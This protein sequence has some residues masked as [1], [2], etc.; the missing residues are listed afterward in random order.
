MTAFSTV[1]TAFDKGGDFETKNRKRN[2]ENEANRTSNKPFNGV[3]FFFFFGIYTYLET[4][5]VE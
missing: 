4:I 1:C 3:Y 2:A 5:Q